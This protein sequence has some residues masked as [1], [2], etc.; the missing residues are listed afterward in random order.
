MLPSAPGGWKSPPQTHTMTVGQEHP[1]RDTG[2]KGMNRLC[3]KG[4]GGSGGGVGGRGGGQG[5]DVYVIHFEACTDHTH[6]QW[7]GLQAA[8]SPSRSAL[9]YE[10]PHSAPGRSSAGSAR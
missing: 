8:V 4:G 1:K 10:Q 7:T 2:R 3:A 5:V 9:T 6:K